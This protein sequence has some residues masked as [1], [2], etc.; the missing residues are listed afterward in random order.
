MDLKTK[1][2]T[3]FPWQTQETGKQEPEETANIQNEPAHHFLIRLAPELGASI[4]C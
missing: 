3:K 2:K 4:A 1:L